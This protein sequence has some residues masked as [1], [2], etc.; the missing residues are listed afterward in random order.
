MKKEDYLEEIYK[1]QCRN[2]RFAKVSEITPL[3]ALK[4]SDPS[5][6]EMIRRLERRN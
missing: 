6:S 3:H 4:V 1:I 5:V 2:N